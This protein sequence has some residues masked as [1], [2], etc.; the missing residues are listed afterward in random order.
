MG[1]VGQRRA[2][3]LALHAGRMAFGLTF[4]LDRA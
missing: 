2:G 4:E 3:G 1:Y